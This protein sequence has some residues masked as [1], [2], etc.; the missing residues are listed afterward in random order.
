MQPNHFKMLNEKKN[1]F[2]VYDFV[3]IFIHDIF[4]YY[5][6]RMSEMQEN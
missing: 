6:V 2:Y 4:A 5:N 3:L 1:L